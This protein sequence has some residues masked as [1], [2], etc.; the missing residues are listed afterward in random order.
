MPASD[1]ARLHAWHKKVTQA[2]VKA[3]GNDPA[4]SPSS[5]KKVQQKRN[6]FPVENTEE[7]EQ[8]VI[9]RPRGRPRKNPLTPPEEKPKRPRGRP[10]KVQSDAPFDETTHRRWDDGLIPGGFG[11]NEVFGSVPVPTPPASAGYGF[12]MG[13]YNNYDDDGDASFKSWNASSP[14]TPSP[15]TPHRS[16]SSPRR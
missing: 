16:L 8:Q 14:D 2:V 6:N 5:S 3:K 10:R 12:G 7:D 1:K 13:V 4:P 9:R 15:G 11:P